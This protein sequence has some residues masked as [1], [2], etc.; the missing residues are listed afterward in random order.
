M[1]TIPAI[2]VN[3]FEAGKTLHLNF[4]AEETLSQ[5][6]DLLDNAIDWLLA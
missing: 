2:M 5:I 4:H 3:K 1:I 6:N